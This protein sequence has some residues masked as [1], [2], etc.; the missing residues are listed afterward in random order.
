MKT[1]AFGLSVGMLALVSRTV[2]ARGDKE[3]DP[4]GPVISMTGQ[5][6]S[7]DAQVWLYRLP[8]ARAPKKKE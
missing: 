8:S 4:P 3:D 1:L 2:P 5:S 7:N 6:G